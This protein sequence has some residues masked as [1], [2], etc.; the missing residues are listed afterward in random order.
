VLISEG[1]ETRAAGMMTE[2]MTT[3]KSEFI[4][5]ICIKL[6]DLFITFPGGKV[7]AIVLL[8]QIFIA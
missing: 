7:S 5:K 6:I 1:G 4:I 8:G 2:A 3:M